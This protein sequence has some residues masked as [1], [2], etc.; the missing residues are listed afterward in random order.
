[1]HYF[2]ENF[3]TSNTVIVTFTLSST[4]SY[5]YNSMESSMTDIIKKLGT[6]SLQAPGKT[7]HARRHAVSNAAV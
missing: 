1:M 5:A 7:P 3:D 6:L 4:N 2:F